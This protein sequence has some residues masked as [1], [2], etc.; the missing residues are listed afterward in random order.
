MYYNYCHKNYHRPDDHVEL[1]VDEEREVDQLVQL[2]KSMRM[3]RSAEVS[4][5]IRDHKLGFQFQHISGYLELTRENAD[6][7][8]TWEFEGGIKPKFYKAVCQRLNL[9]NQGSDAKVTGFESYR[10]RWNMMQ[11]V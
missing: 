11:T 2:F 8:D 6:G 1:T 4:R 7:V 3:T 10:D 5:Y 9:A